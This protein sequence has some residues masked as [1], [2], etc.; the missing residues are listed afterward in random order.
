[1]ALLSS[2]MGLGCFYP[3][4]FPSVKT[5]GYFQKTQTLNRYARGTWPLGHGLSS[6]GFQTTVG[7]DLEIA[8]PWKRF[9]EQSGYNAATLYKPSSS[10]LSTC[11]PL[12]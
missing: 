7:G 5:L 12:D 11:A 6:G 3:T 2:L 9:A 10:L 1:M 4:D 8:L